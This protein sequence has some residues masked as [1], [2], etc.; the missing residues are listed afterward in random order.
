MVH[1]ILNAL[2]EA[3]E[4]GLR[5]PLVYNS[6]GYDLA[7]TIKLLDDVFDIY[8]PD[9]KY[10]DNTIASAFSGVEDY[11]EYVSDSLFEMHRQVGDLVADQSG[12][13]QRGLIIRHLI[14]PGHISNTKKVIDFVRSLS[15]RTFLNL[16]DQY[17][18]AYKA[19][20]YG[21]LNRRITSTEY[22]EAY[23]YAIAV[24]LLRLAG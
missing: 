18:P 21:S 20:D 7:S 10:M 12:V 24:G 14:M 16:M 22:Q 23:D 13:A 17:H 9:I 2:P 4:M 3:I 1:A 6:G 15:S 5:I 8:M 19:K 11:I